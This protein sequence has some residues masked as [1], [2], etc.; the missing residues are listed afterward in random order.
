MKRAATAA[1]IAALALIASSARSEPLPSAPVAPRPASLAYYAP[2]VLPYVPGMPVFT[3]YHLEHRR[4]RPLL[5]ASAYLTSA[6]VA[7][8]VLLGQ[9]R[10]R[11]EVAPLYAPFAGPFATLGTSRNVQLN[12][13]YERTNG[14][15]LIASGVVQITGAALFIA[16]LATR[17]TRQVRD[18]RERDRWSDARAQSRRASVELTPVVSPLGVGLHGAF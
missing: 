9:D 3:G 17:E 15:V 7:T 6:F 14:I 2:S 12:D 5:F 10:H 16:G 1:T 11:F 13:P 18:T 8:A 4:N